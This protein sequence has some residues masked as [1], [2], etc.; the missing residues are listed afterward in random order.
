MRSAAAA[1]AAF[2]LIAA[3]L[4]Y[5]KRQV[6]YARSQLDE[7]TKLRMDQTRPFVV[8][9]FEPRKVFLLLGVENYGPTLAK[10]IEIHFDP[11]LTST[12]DKALADLSNF[13]STGI[14]TLVPRKRIRYFFD[15]SHLRSASR[16]CRSRCD[17]R[18]H[19]R[20]SNGR[21]QASERADQD[22][23]GDAARSRLD[24]DHDGPALRVG[25]HGGRRGPGQHAD[26]AAHDGEQD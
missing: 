26:E 8:A 24:G 19:P 9:D 4:F 10:N 12:Q 7:A 25:V 21:H 17:G 20:R 15:V 22:G 13:L 16:P 23:R 11:P 5:A 1:W 6:G 14:P 18:R 3:S 2:F